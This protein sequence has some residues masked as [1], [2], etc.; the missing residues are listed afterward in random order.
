MS[1]PNFHFASEE[2]DNLESLHQWLAYEL[3]SAGL[4]GLAFLLPYRYVVLLLKLAAFIFTPYMLW[5]L[6]KAGRFGWIAGF[7]ITV[8]LPFL[9]GQRADPTGI[10]TGFLLSIL[11]LITFYLYTWA[12]RLHLSEWLMEAQPL[13]EHFAA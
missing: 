12:L 4:S 7:F 3:S 8:G 10:I 13:D 9:Y 1:E 11:P 2:Y 5:R 6:F